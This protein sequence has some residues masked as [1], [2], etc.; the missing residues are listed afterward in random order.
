MD[1]A[2]KRTLSRRMYI[3][4]A[5]AEY[6]ISILVTGSFFAAVTREMGFSDSLTGILSAVISL[7]CL[8]QLLSMAF[9][10]GRSKRFVI[11]LSIVN[12]LLFSLLYIIPLTG[13]PQTTKTVLFVA[14]VFIAYLIYYIA[15][16]KKITWMMS[17]VDENK[18]GSFTSLKEAVSLLSGMAFS[19]GMGMVVDHF[20]AQNETQTAFLICVGA[21]AV[22]TVVHTVSMLLT[23]EQQE[24]APVKK[25][26]LM[27]SIRQTL[28]DRNL[29][30]VIVLLVLYNIANYA[31]AP[32]YGAYQINDLGFTLQFISI[33]SIVSSGFRIAAS[34][35]WGRYADRTSFLNM[36]GKCLLFVMA[37]ALCVVFAVPANGKVMFLL[38]YILSGI[39]QGG[40]NSA[41]MNI[42]FDC[43]PYER[44]ADS[45]AVC[46]AVS[47]VIGFVT[48]LAVSPLVAFIQTNGNSFMGISI[49]AQQVTA[50]ISFVLLALTLV[51][52]FRCRRS[53]RKA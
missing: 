1:T 49:Y 7:G 22:F 16:P 31:S 32:F 26:R 48:T 10:P 6:L 11:I 36:M 20:T 14:A 5:A 41:L 44:R 52:S 27:D 50:V 29:L 3:I 38:Y 39:A 46:Q 21:I 53:I 47:G 34:I 30:H 23:M 43:V 33:L 28:T 13:L 42:I 19:Y 35:F 51:Y 24:E 9:H 4:E 37:A 40:V 45:L 12:Q 17:M 18:R 25:L 15:H 8:F 2:A